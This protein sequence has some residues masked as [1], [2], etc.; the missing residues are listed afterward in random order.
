V[1]LARLLEP[2]TMMNTLVPAWALKVTASS[3]AKRSRAPW[4]VPSMSA[5]SKA[6]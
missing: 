1:A 6:T 2:S 4:Q 5:Q 3:S